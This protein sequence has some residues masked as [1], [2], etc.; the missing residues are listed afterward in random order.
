MYLS[1]LSLNRTRQAYLWVSNPYRVHQRL[2][3]ACDGDPRLLFRIETNERGVQIIVQSVNIPDWDKGFENFPVLAEPAE[4][5]PFDPQLSAGRAYRFRL[6]AN[7]TVKETVER[8]GKEPGKTRLGL[9]RE[10]D[11]LA[12]L[13]RKLEAAGANR[14]NCHIIP[15]GM[16]QSHANPGK[17]QNGQTH[18]AVLFDGILQVQDPTALVAAIQAGIGS[19][20]GFGFGLLSLAPVA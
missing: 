5:K 9:I 2:M 6:L 10:E 7:P 20:K 4:S 13:Q 1:R 19:A 15:R 14:I 12:W 16:Q 18:L 3:M 8:E 11:Q 17:D